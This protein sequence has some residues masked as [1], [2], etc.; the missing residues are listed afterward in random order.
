MKERRGEKKEVEKYEER[1]KK[2]KQEERREE[3]EKGRE[4]ERGGWVKKREKRVESILE[5]K[6]RE[7]KI[8]EGRIRYFEKKGEDN[9]DSLGMKR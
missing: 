9:S 1:R 7:N 6:V 3:E 2:E 8:Q 4:V 5:R